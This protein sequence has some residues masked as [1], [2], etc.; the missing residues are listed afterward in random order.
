MAT[1]AQDKFYH[2]ARLNGAA[3][4]GRYFPEMEAAPPA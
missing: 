2:R 3:R 1:E 4:N